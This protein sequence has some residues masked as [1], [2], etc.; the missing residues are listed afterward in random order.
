M[1]TPDLILQTL[2]VLALIYS[3]IQLREVPD[4]LDAYSTTMLRWFL[5]ILA[6]IAI[7]NL[8]SVPLDLS[9]EGADLLDTVLDIFRFLAPV[10]FLI[11]VHAYG[12]WRWQTAINSKQNDYQS[13]LQQLPGVSYRSTG[14][15]QALLIDVSDGIE[16]L[17]G[18][19]AAEFRGEKPR[20]LLDFMRAEDRETMLPTYLESLADNR[21]FAFEYR[22]QTASG[23]EV[24]VIDRGHRVARADG[25]GYVV[26]GVLLNASRLV[27]AEQEL[28]DQEEHMRAQQK[29]LLRLCEFSGSL[30]HAVQL[31]TRIMAETLRT[32]RASVWLYSQDRSR[33]ECLDLYSRDSD[34]HEHNLE[35]N[36]ADYPGY[37]GFMEFGDVIAAENAQQDERTCELNEDYL[38]PLNIQS[39]MDTPFKIDGEVRGI[40]C[41]EQQDQTKKWSIDEQNFA[42]SVANVVSLMLE[43][44]V[45]RQ[46]EKD[47]RLERDRAQSYLDTVNV[48]IISLDNEGFVRLVNNRACE[49]L[50]YSQEEF[51][52][53]H[54]VSTFIPEEERN[55]LLNAVSVAYKD[56]GNLRSSY[57]NHVLT[58]DGERLLI[59][60]SNAYQTDE[61]GRII[62]LLA[63]GEDITELTK[64]REEKERLQDEMQQVQK[65]R[66]IVQLTGGVAHDFNNMLTSIMGYADLAQISMKRNAM[67][68]SDRYLAAIRATSKKAGNL[69]SQLLDYSRENVLVKEPIN[70]NTL[71]EESR[72]MLEA[73]MSSSVQIVDNLDPDLPNVLANQTQLQQVVINLCQNAKEALHNKDATL[74][75]STSVKEVRDATCESCF[76]K[77]SGHYVCLEIADNGVG[78]NP[79]VRG[80]IFDPFTTTKDVGEGTGL[81]LSAV[82]GIVHMHGG[83][84]L[85]QSS[86]DQRTRFSILLPM[87]KS[88]NPLVSDDSGHKAEN[89]SAPVTRARRDGPAKVLLVDDDESVTRLLS[90]F[91]ER[92]GIDCSAINSSEQAWELFE[93][94]SEEFDIVITDHTMPNL[95]GI[96]LIKKIRSV[97]KN[98]PIVLCSGFNE[99]V[100]EDEATAL[101]VSRFLNKP[102]RLENLAS[103]I[104]ELTGVKQ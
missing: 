58:K 100:N 54:W 74:W 22:L 97:N 93:Q 11:F 71:I 23:D 61:N 10:F 53:K 20:S 92:N 73:M 15:S 38:T 68:D 101:G 82:H 37:F 86:P 64:Q 70:L 47:L 17:L 77:T 42:R 26:E 76:Q 90:S 102:I 18:I 57:E 78:I 59:R 24:W 41:A 39:L 103:V 65:M 12:Q 48:M 9:A 16:A 85:V 27:T 94:K 3:L 25:K 84:I 89:E 81:G 49:L 19:P 6:G 35:L 96:E 55:D 29:A 8:I 91:F 87:Q 28:S 98:I 43:I 30:E 36:L 75:I 13:M 83:H 44:S 7:C 46:I 62:G 1:N 4:E 50:G 66:S 34:A 56:Q 95:T 69:V 67:V 45:N 40:V 14:D 21:P 72:R 2:A 99:L 80:H 88:S 33:I 52:G 51:R 31:V 104:S 63:A 32:S 79:A 60:W 5:G